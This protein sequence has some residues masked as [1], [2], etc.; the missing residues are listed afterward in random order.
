MNDIK[1]KLELWKV[2]LARKPL[3]YFTS[4]EI[5]MRSMDE[6]NLN[7]LPFMAHFETPQKEF[8]ERFKDFS[9]LEPAVNI[10]AN[11]FAMIYLSDMSP[12]IARSLQI[13][14]T[15]VFEIEIKNLRNYIILKYH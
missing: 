14:D 2:N 8:S 7:T 3:S 9:I 15:V 1:C 13:E 5:M 4:L 11:S 6:A 12:C 10:F